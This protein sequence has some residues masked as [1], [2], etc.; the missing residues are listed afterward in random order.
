MMSTVDLGCTGREWALRRRTGVVPYESADPDTLRIWWTDAGV[1]QNLNF[2]STSTRS[3]DSSV[4]TRRSGYAEPNRG[5]AMV[6]SR[7]T[8]PSRRPP[9]LSWLEKT[10][11]A[12]RVSSDGTR[13]PYWLMRPLKRGREVFVIPE[14]A[15]VP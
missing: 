4:G 3:T 14:A 2:A 1:H 13:R 7:L 11:S 9:N 8:P 12:R 5:T 6:T 15:N 10:C